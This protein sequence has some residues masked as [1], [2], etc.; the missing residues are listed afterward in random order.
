MMSG[1][2]QVTE[3]GFHPQGSPPASTPTLVRSRPKLPKIF[4]DGGR[5]TDGVEDLVGVISTLGSTDFVEKYSTKRRKRAC[6]AGTGSSSVGPGSGNAGIVSP[7]LSPRAKSPPTTD[8]GSKSTITLTRMRSIKL[9]LE[10]VKQRQERDKESEKAAMAVAGPRRKT[11]TVEPPCIG[12]GGLCLP[13][14]SDAVQNALHQSYS[15]PSLDHGQSD[16][17]EQALSTSS[18]SVIQSTSESQ[19]PEQ[20]AAN[21]NGG[22]D[23][24]NTGNTFLSELR[25][26]DRNLDTNTSSQLV[27]ETLYDSS[28]EFQ[29]KNSDSSKSTVESGKSS[30]D[31]LLYV[32]TDDERLMSMSKRMRTTDVKRD[33]E[34]NAEEDSENSANDMEDEGI[35]AMDIEEDRTIDPRLLDK[36]A[37]SRNAGDKT[38]ENGS[39]S[40]T[41]GGGK[42]TQALSPE[43]QQDF[44]THGPKDTSTCK[45][46]GEQSTSGKRTNGNARFLTHPP[47]KEK[48]AP[49]EGGS[50]DSNGLGAL[51]TDKEA[52]KTNSLSSQV[53]EVSI[54]SHIYGSETLDTPTYRDVVIDVTSEPTGVD[55][56]EKKNNRSFKHKSKSDPS[57][58]KQKQLEGVDLDLPI[59]LGAHTQSVPA[60]MDKDTSSLASLDS[61]EENRAKSK[62]DNLLTKPP[63]SPHPH[64]SRLRETPLTKSTSEESSEEALPPAQKLVK[65]RRALKKRRAGAVDAA[66][67]PLASRDRESSREELEDSPSPRTRER[68]A[69]TLSP[70]STVERTPSKVSL[71]LPMA[72]KPQ[73]HA[74]SRSHSSAVDYGHKPSQKYDAFRSPSPNLGARPKSSDNKTTPKVNKGRP[75]I[76]EPLT[77]QKSFTWAGSF[78]SVT[79]SGSSPEVGSPRRTGDRATY[80]P[81]LDTIFSG[82]SLSLF[83]GAAE[84]KVNQTFFAFRPS[85]AVSWDG[86]M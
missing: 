32:A 11:G 24:P 51:R 33:R 10:E 4:S 3:A 41:S 63:K 80:S 44:S 59:V 5:Q 70:E 46:N 76:P 22:N 25:N 62:S 7:V 75:P 21:D 66:R 34:D 69:M 61:S 38:T 57:G 86:L 67:L 50:V 47:S 79:G 23:L 49:R 56:F 85:A 81:R 45:A 73:H 77:S 6:V 15:S 71:T 83:E 18:P 37:L 19:E 74:I 68:H 28:M 12:F 26:K 84:D 42:S 78:G 64:I 14:P 43:V 9:K 1:Q 55:K 29:H 13:L 8:T 53:S 54:D 36:L 60:L 39:V 27:S 30:S 82:S 2:V 31:D 65:A 35:G 58:E 17:S 16:R 72:R 48:P 40:S 52:M 20:E